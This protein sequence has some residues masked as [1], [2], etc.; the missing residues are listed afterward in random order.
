[1]RVFD[2]PRASLF[3]QLLIGFEHLAN[4]RRA[5]RMTVAD[6]T[7]TSVHWNLERSFEL[8]RTHLRQRCRPAFHK[9]DT[10]ARLGE[11]ENFIGNDF[12][13]RKTIVNIGAVEIARLQVRHLKSFLGSFARYRKRW[14]IL[15]VER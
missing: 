5:D 3:S 11:S 15:L 9:L 1:F 7:A 6:Q 2:L 8:L 10:L 14:G 13:N 12:C 4:S